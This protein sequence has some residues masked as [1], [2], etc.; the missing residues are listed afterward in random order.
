MSLLKNSADADHI[1]INERILS[2][3]K[4][5]YAWRLDQLKKGQIEIRTAQTQ[6]DL[7]ELQAGQLMDLLEMKEGSASFDDYRVLIGVGK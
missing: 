5:T 7:E 2:K 1:D 3:M 4:A 6:A